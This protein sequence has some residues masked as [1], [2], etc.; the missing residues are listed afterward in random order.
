M[1]ILDLVSRNAEL[2]PSDTAL[3]ELKPSTNY[4]RTIT[5][6]EFDDKINR[7]ATAMA[8][9]GIGREDKVIHLMMN[10]IDWLI[11][12][13]AIL[14]T[15]AWAVPLN[16]RFTSKDILYCANISE[17]ST[18]I[19]GPEF[20]ERLDAARSGLN[21]I[22]NYIYTGLDVPPGMEDMHEMIASSEPDAPQL[23]LTPGDIS[24]L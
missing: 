16:F 6:K 7:L 21:L 12:Y 5:W 3:V 24:S 15:G 22:K 18:M 19:V 2:Y 1:T 14:K 17:A 23:G 4:R 9:R 13:F 10:S 11:A 8:T 20:I